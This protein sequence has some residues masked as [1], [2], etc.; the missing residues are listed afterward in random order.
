MSDN[1]Y[2]LKFWRP[3][4]KNTGAA[5]I[6]DYKPGADAVWL[7]MAPQNASGEGFDFKK[8]ISTKLNVFEIAQLLAVSS[9][10]IDALGDKNTNGYYSGLLH[11]IKG[12]T[13]STII[14]LAPAKDKE[15]EVTRF[16]SV[17]A[18]REQDKTRL[19]VGLGIGELVALAEFC[20]FII[21][22]ML[23]Q[24]AYQGGG[25][26]TPA[27]TNKPVAA[28]AKSSAAPAKKTVRQPVQAEPEDGD[29]I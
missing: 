2:E 4:G 7:S 19:S 24:E 5:A 3:N 25:D 8:K 23:M 15:Q 11:Q 16:L 26:A 9:G 20:R 12:Q 22:Q 28:P 21:P 10:R 18:T 13:N 14:G 29:P 27:Q 17:S 1:K 6:F